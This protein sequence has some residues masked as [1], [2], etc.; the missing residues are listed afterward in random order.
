MKNKIYNRSTFWLGIFFWVLSLFSV[1]ELIFFFNSMGGGKVLKTF[2]YLVFTTTV[3]FWSVQ[4]SLSYKRTKKAEQ[5]KDEREELVNLKSDHTT[6][7]IIQIVSFILMVA[8]TIVWYWSNVN[9][10]IFIVIA[11][12]L[13]FNLILFSKLFTYLYYNKKI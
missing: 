10:L 4:E 9:E 2:I 3:G 8:G 1:I 5:E 7:T 12:G 13:I 6:I 11:F